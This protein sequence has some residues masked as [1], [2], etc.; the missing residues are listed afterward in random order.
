[1]H[2]YC[3]QV[4]KKF[5]KDFNIPLAKKEKEIQVRAHTQTKTYNQ[6][7]SLTTRIQLW[8][9]SLRP[10]NSQLVKT[11]CMLYAL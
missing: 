9:R 8:F 5:F 3:M 7:I 1:M 2:L 11:S 6:H 4:E 10:S